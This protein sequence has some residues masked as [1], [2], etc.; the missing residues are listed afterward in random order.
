MVLVPAGEFQMGCD[1]SNPSESCYSNEKPLHTVY[2]NAYTI[3]N[4][5]V[6]NAQYAHCV[7]AGSCAAP[8][9]QGSSTRGSYYSNPAFADY[10]VIHVNWHS[11]RDYCDWANKRLP[12]EAEWEKAA[13]GSSDTRMYPWGNQG[14]D[15]TR[16]NFYHDGVNCV[17]DTSE[18]SSY[19]GGASPCGVLDMAGNGWEWV[20]DWYESDYYGV[21]PYSNPTGPGSGSHRVMR[22]GS[23]GDRSYAIRVAYRGHASPYGSNGYIGFRCAADAPGA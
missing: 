1:S 22:G 10:P 14:A 17:G 20:A 8:T 3:D 11:A 4:T 19:P 2:S 15:C 6:T 23:W 16:A 12:T 7:V 13:R 18:V 21:S 9:N 5:E